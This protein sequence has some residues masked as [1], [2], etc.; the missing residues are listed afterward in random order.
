[1]VEERWKSLDESGREKQERDSSE[2]GEER[3]VVMCWDVFRGVSGWRN[4]DGNKTVFISMRRRS[5]KIRGAGST[6]GPACHQLCVWA[7]ALER[8]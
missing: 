1:M 8:K 2:Q 7:E 5:K 6:K 3:C 4:G